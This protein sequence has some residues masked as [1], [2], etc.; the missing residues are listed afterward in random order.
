MEKSKTVIVNVTPQPQIKLKE[1]RGDEYDPN[2]AAMAPAAST[3]NINASSE[4]TQ[5]ES[6]S[7]AKFPSTKLV[8]NLKYLMDLKAN[9]NASTQTNNNSKSS[10]EAFSE[11]NKYDMK[12]DSTPVSITSNNNK[13][14]ASNSTDRTFESNQQAQNE[15]YLSKKEEDQ[16]IQPNK[17]AARSNQNIFPS[18]SS[19]YYNDVNNRFQMQNGSAEVIMIHDESNSND[20][21]SSNQSDFYNPFR[22]DAANEDQTNTTE[23][24]NKN[25]NNASLAKCTFYNGSKVWTADLLNEK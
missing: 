23:K 21:N 9:E 8:S 6:Y 13:P 25:L 12:N 2:A 19:S 4:T 14:K 20:R 7:N 1:D 22:K 11:E 17:T 16:F 18:Q 5:N 3:V 15:Q 10:K 24:E